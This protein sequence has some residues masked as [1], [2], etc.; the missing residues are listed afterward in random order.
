MHAMRFRLVDSEST[1][2]RIRCVHVVSVALILL[3]V[4]AWSLE[5]QGLDPRASG[6]LT[7]QWRARV[8]FGA[9]VANPSYTDPY[10]I[11]IHAHG[12]QRPG[13][14]ILGDFYFKSTSPTG[15][16]SAAFSGFRATSGLMVGPRGVGGALTPVALSDGKTGDTGP[17]PYFGVGYTDLPHRTGWGFSA[18][19]GLMAMNPR[20]AV[21]FGGVLGG[22]QNIDDLLRE[23]RLAPL[24]Q[25]GVSY[26][27]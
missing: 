24:L 27:F 1:T 12:N 5:G 19:F 10:N 18:D 13:L 4:P 26:S 17:V 21:K 20:S 25:L 14:S 6:W 16:P 7:D 3:G 2:M 15:K 11:A 23:L 22:P 8:E 9:G